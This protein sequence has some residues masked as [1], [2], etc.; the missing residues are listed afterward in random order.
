M[1]LVGATWRLHLLIKTKCQSLA[2]EDGAWISA[3]PCLPDKE[4]PIPL[5]NEFDLCLSPFMIAQYIISVVEG[6]WHFGI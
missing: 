4:S 2:R 6:L 1:S 5:F 3:S